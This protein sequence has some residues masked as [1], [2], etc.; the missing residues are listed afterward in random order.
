MKICGIYCIRNKI[1]G[2]VYIGS[3]VDIHA[4]WRTHRYELRGG[5]HHSIALQRAWDKYGR[6]AFAFEVL[7]EIADMQA[8]LQ[9]ETELIAQHGSADGL[10]GYNCLPVAGSP[11]G[12]KPSEETRRRMSEAQ[13]QIPYEVRLTYCRSWVGRK[14]SEETKAKMSASSPRRKPTPEERAANSVRHKGKT[15]SAENKAIVGAITAARNKTPEQR[16]KVSAALKGRVFTPEWRQ[17][18]RDAAQRRHAKKAQDSIPT[19]QR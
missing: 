2:K 3:S 14:H 16:A 13:K 5:G 1:N 10:N 6:E 8:R 9:R 18:L 4:R 15:I 19:S 11:L 17:K 7:E 12:V